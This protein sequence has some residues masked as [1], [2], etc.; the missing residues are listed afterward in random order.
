MPALLCILHT[1][2]THTPYTPKNPHIHTPTPHTSH[3]HTVAM[4]SLRN[5]IF[6]KTLCMTANQFLSVHYNL[7]SLYGLTEANATMR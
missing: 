3:T 5:G 7:H 1:S 4:R 6:T 2:F